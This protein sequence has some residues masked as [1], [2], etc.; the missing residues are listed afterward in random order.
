[1]KQHLYFFL[2]V[3]VITICGCNNTEDP[4]L[5]QPIPIQEQFVIRSKRID[6]SDV[7][8]MNQ[9]KN[10]SRKCFIINSIDDYPSDNLGFSEAYY[11]VDFSSYTILLYYR[12]HKWELESF[13]YSFYY[14]IPNNSYNWL[15]QLGLGSN[16]NV[17]LN[18]HIFSRFAIKVRK[19]PTNSDIIANDEVYDI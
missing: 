18:Y 1:M 3:I 9:C 11:N 8:L 12:L 13:R 2:T 14:S 5:T 17:I 15:I 7:H 19:I 16:P 6:S 10:L 4:T